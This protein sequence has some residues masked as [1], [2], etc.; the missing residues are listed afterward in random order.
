ME[1]AAVVPDWLTWLAAGAAG[2]VA[3]AAVARVLETVLDFE[4]R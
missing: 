2:A 3:F 4:L 1:I